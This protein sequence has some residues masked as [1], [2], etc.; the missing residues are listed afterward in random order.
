MATDS[1]PRRPSELSISEMERM[2][3]YPDRLAK[4]A[5]ERELNLLQIELVKMQRWV[6][7]NHERI[8]I[9]FEGRDAAGKG[10]SIRR[11]TEHLNPRF[12]RVAALAKPNDTERTQW[13][14]QRYVSHLPAGGEIVLFDR[15][16]YN[17]AGVE[18]VMGFCTAS[19]YAE[20]FRQ[21]PA[22]E[23][24]LVQ[25]GIRM[26]KLW[27]TVSKQEQA[28]RFDRRRDDPL[29]QWKLSP[30]D[31]E[32]TRLFAQYGKARNAM[33]THTDH[34]LA[35]WTIVNS[36]EKRRARLES[37]RHILHSVPYDN[38]EPTVVHAPDPRVVRPASEVDVPATKRP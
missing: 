14:F 13:Y 27:F 28:R 7:D 34:S 15:S 11:F 35:P 37:I 1:E 31:A 25:S 19:E 32:A 3:P 26:F 23:Q 21:A 29:S 17:R 6:R 30:M 9:V 36:N 4:K 10:G 38:K 2:V 24:S 33:L 12:A 8:A 18:H 22:F 20:F 5:Y 16:W